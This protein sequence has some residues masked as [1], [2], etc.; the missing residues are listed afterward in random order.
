MIGTVSRG[1]RAPIIRGGDNLV[2]IVTESIY[3]AAKDGG[4][5]IRNR[6]IVAMTESIVARAQENYVTIDDIAADV[7]AKF[8]GET[9]GIIFPILSRNRF[10]V[11]LT[12]IAR[13][14]K[15]VVIML[16]YPSDEVG[17]HLVSFDAIDAAGINPYSD[18]LDIKRYREC[19]G[20]EKHTFTGVDYVEYYE[21]LVRAEGAECEIIFANDA[22]AILAHTQ[23]GTVETGA[24]RISL[25]A[26]NT[27]EEVEKFIQIIGDIKNALGIL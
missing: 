7:R 4:Y 26:Y 21:N 20:Y 1:V 5:E 25:N 11:C 14:A 17:N 24:V 6:D 12:G 18:V 9:V 27:P 2:D 13:G 10:S 22:R 23:I 19:F 3:E 8:G 15:K 16:S